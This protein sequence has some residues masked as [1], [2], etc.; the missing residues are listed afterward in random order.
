MEPIFISFIVPVYNRA[1]ELQELC[2]SLCEQT[3]QD[4][5]IVVV[6][7]GSPQPCTAVIA[8]FSQR[9]NIRYISIAKR[10][11]SY[12]RNRGCE[13][14]RGNF[15]VFVDS[16]CILPPDYVAQLHTHLRSKPIA[17]FGGPDKA[18]ESF[19]V[20]QKAVNFVMTSFLTTGGTRGGSEKMTKFQ[21]RSFNMGFERQV[22]ERVGGFPENMSRGED[23]ELSNRIIRAGVQ[24]HLLRDVFVYHKRRATTQTFARQM[25]HFACGRVRVGRIHPGSMT[26]LHYAPLVLGMCSIGCV[27][28]AIFLSPLFALPLVGFIVLIFC[29]ALWTTQNLRVACV[30]VY[31]ACIQI[32]SYGCGT[33][34]ETLHPRDI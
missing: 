14:A 3:N 29:A 7:D 11:P 20:F 8:A 5:E 30:S 31:V 6:E 26:P 12:A 32:Y 15:F 33:L 18:H 23:I 13:A 28:G 4:F 24:A 2:D 27:V 34:H 25:Y 19:R 21:P 10:G 9:L 17:Y 1:H 16:D 22:Y